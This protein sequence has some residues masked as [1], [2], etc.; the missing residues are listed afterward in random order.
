MMATRQTAAPVGRKKLAQGKERGGRAQTPTLSHDSQNA[1]SHEGA[2]EGGALPKGWRRVA[3]KDM[4]DSI[5]YGL[6]ASAAER[7][8]IGRAH[9]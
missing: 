4:A 8:E 2:K 9:V 6:T 7:K 5:Q 3:I 1:S